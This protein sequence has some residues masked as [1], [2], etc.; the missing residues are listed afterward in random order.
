MFYSKHT[1]VIHITGYNSFSFTA[2]PSDPIVE[3]VKVF[4]N[5][6]A[7]LTCPYKLGRLHEDLDPY[8]ISWVIVQGEATVPA[9]VSQVSISD[10]M[11]SILRV[12]V[13][14]SEI[15]NGAMYRC[16]LMLR[17]CERLDESNQP[18]SDMRRCGIKT[19]TSPGIGVTIY[20]ESV[21]TSIITNI[22][23]VNFQNQ[24]N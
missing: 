20:G 7:T 18:T 21:Y 4:A 1:C 11:F 12:R 9:E 13:P 10:E 8:D 24:A 16:T 2:E 14:A 23:Y 3:N 6:E 19:F 17:K 22:D 5:S 15:D